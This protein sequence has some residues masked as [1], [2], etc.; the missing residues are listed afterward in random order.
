MY[1]G[2]PPPYPSGPGGYYGQPTQ[3]NVYH[4]QQPGIA[5]YYQTVAA[6]QPQVIY[7]HER[8]GYNNGYR[9]GGDDC[10]DCCCLTACLAL[11]CCCCL[12]GH[13]C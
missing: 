8:S 5:P 9:R 11:L 1:S 6:P 13:D 12:G 7:V 10:C 3:G 4:Q 2:P